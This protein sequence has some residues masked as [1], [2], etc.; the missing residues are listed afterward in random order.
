VTT[1]G[2]RTVRNRRSF[3]QWAVRVLACLLV[4]L[5]VGGAPGSAL[6]LGTGIFGDGSDGNVTI[7]TDTTLTRDMYFNTLIVAPGVHLD[8][9]GF[10]IFVRVRCT[11][12]GTIRNN[13]TTGAGAPAGTTGG[14]G[15]PGESVVDSAGG[16]GGPS[17]GFAGPPT[18][19]PPS[20]EHGGVDVL[21]ALP[22]AITGTLA[23]TGGTVRIRGGAGGGVLVTSSGSATG[24]G[25]GVVIIAARAFAGTGR[26]EANG[27]AGSTG[28]GILLNGGGGGG[29][30]VTVSSTTLGRIVTSV[31]GGAG[32]GAGEAGMVFHVMD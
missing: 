2:E 17:F 31:A 7:S 19:T 28:S 29:V 26:I 16:D 3:A 24:G 22:Y 9:G 1:K 25:G 30:I 6:A 12:N 8:T 21:R 11:I 4:V 15:A 23:G 18:A 27:G 10:R 32:S 13:G 20:A 5:L 14:G